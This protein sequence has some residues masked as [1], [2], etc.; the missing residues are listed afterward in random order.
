[1]TLGERVQLGEAAFVEAPARADARDA[2]HEAQMARAAADYVRTTRSTAQ[3]LKST[4]QIAC[5][6]S[7]ELKNPRPA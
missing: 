2:Q 4:H 5:S 3:V 1:M 6:L 7:Q